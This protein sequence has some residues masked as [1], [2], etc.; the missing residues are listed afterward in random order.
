M[1]QPTENIRDVLQKANDGWNSAFNSGNADAVA[2]HYTPDAVVL[3]ST[4]AFIR[5]TSAIKDFWKELI[6]A[7]V[8][9]HGIELVDAVAAGD[10]AYATGKWSA[11]GGETQRYEGSIVTIFRRETDGSWR[12]CLH[13]W[14]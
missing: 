7:G 2:A 4:H 8:G 1:A 12:V 10:I 13:T 5:G 14:N 6:S 11:E 3:P 9:N